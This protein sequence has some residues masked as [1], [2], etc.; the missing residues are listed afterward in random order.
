MRIQYWHEGVHHVLHDAGALPQ[1]RP[2]LFDPFHW[3]AAGRVAGRAEGRGRVVFVRGGLH[4]EVFALRHYRRGGQIGRFIEDTYL[5]LGLA[6][7][8][9]WREFALTC[10]LFAK[11]LPVPRPI[12][13]HVERYGLA[14]TA[15]LLTLRIPTA[16]P[17]A[18]VLRAGA[19]PPAHW[20]LLGKTIR[21]FHA[22]GVRHDDINARNILRDARHTFHLIDFD[23]ARLLPQGPW[24]EQNLARFRRS[25]DKFKA[26]DAAFHFEEGDW[27]ALL[28][29][30]RS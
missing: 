26:A 27:N 25:L 20:T 28:S 19:M 14:Y 2:E 16:E 21:R 30:Y 17:L 7:T 23:R 12:A 1:P 10:E 18:D 11:G 24:Q 15:D 8:R 22:A 3:E 13:A 9:A 5:W 29:G 4:D 6:Q